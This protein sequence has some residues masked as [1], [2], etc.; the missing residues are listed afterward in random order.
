MSVQLTTIKQTTTYIFARC[1]WNLNCMNFLLLRL[2]KSMSINFIIITIEFVHKL[3]G[4]V[5]Q[6]RQKCLFVFESGNHCEC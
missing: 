6:I 1:I 4:K 2:V 5:F 3:F